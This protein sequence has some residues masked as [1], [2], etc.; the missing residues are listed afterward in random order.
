M[1]SFLSSVYNFIFSNAGKWFLIGLAFVIL[2]ILYYTARLNISELK[3]TIAQKDQEIEILNDNIVH[4]NTT[5][6]D[7]ETRLSVKQSESDNIQSLLAKCYQDAQEQRKYLDE[8]ETIMN[9]PEPVT[10]IT[11][12]EDVPDESTEYTKVT[13]YQTQQGLMFVNRQFERILDTN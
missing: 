11:T 9:T 7:C 1:L 13:P 2:L 10:D 12:N 4:L 5:I 8:I 6:V 3:L